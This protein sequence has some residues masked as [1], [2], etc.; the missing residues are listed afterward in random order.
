MRIGNHAPDLVTFRASCGRID[1]RVFERGRPCPAETL[2]NNYNIR[3][4]VRYGHGRRLADERQAA[5]GEQ[6]LHDAVERVLHLQ[7]R[8]V[9][10]V[11]LELD[12]EVATRRDGEFTR[13]GQHASSARRVQACSTAVAITATATAATV[14]AAAARAWHADFA[15]HA[16]IIWWTS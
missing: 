8:R 7:T 5:R 4:V 10:A 11:V 6:R 3:G 1:A 15:L 16:C 9:E 13:R 14:V 12:G 2:A